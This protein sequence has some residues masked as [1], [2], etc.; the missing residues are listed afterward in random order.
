M[1]GIHKIIVRIAN[2]ADPNQTASDLGLLCFSRPFWQA[3][4]YK[5]SVQSFRTFTIAS[6]TI[7]FSRK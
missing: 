4:Y 7:T 6:L 5:I 1:A 2:K 3:T